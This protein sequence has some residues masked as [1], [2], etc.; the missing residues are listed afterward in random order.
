MKNKENIKKFEKQ[1]GNDNTEINTIIKIVVG[2]IIFL[3]L[4]YF[5]MG[6][7]TGDIKLGK[8]KSEET[9]IQYEEILAER[10]FKQKDTEYFVMFYN[11]SDDDAL[12]QAV[13][14]NLGYLKKVYK[15][16]LDKKFNSNYIGEINNN[17]TT[18]ENLK[19]KSP[20]LIKIKN[21]KAI[22][23]VM[24]LDSIKKYISTLN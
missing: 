5:L 2:I 7:I 3:G 15:V 16:D 10:T 6:L 24:G 12:L 19:V 22:K 18:I 8:G 17:P 11:F 21:G 4:A 1:I 23:V 13:I 20:T 14:E 9:S